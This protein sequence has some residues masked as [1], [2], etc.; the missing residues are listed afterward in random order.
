MI[1]K[2]KSGEEQPIVLEN[3][4]GR[5]TTIQLWLAVII[6]IFVGGWVVKDQVWKTKVDMRLASIEESVGDRW[7][8]TQM[9]L[10]AAEVSRL[11]PTIRIPPTTSHYEPVIIVPE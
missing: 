9:A 2:S 4:I 3:R 5:N 7:T 10:W 1:T 11:N 8:K 6:A